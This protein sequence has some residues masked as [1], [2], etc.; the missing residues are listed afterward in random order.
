MESIF[1]AKR[2]GYS[3]ADSCVDAVEVLQIGQE[4][5]ACMFPF[6]LFF[7]LNVTFTEIGGGLRCA[8]LTCRY[9]RTT[10]HFMLN[11]APL[12]PRGNTATHLSSHLSASFKHLWFHIHVSIFQSHTQKIKGKNVKI[13]LL[14]F[15]NPKR[16]PRQAGFHTAA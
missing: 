5:N 13:A 8:P 12:F 4:L 9:E 14:L 2:D 10:G 11:I 7:F 1:P 3:R 6:F 16:I 15:R